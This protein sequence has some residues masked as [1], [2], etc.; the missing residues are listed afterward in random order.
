MD[1]FCPHCTRRV[2]VPDDKAGQVLS[3]PLCAKQFQAPSL[4]PPP[5]TPKAPPPP[6]PTPETKYSA[7]EPPQ[8]PATGVPED[9][10]TVETPQ[11]MG[12]YARSFAIVF[13]S[14]WLAFVPP[15]CLFLIFILS[16]FNWHH[17]DQDHTASLWG[18]SFISQ[19]QAGDVKQAH[20]LAYTI[21]M[22]FPT[23][24]LVAA[25]FA[26]NKAPLPPQVM[27]VKGWLDLAAGLFL[28][29]TF[30]MLC[31]D[32]LDA[33]F[34]ARNNAIALAMKLAIRLHFLAMMASFLMF[35]LHL[36]SR[37]NLPPPRLEVRF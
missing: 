12:D 3:C 31:I 36:R 29:L 1:L 24:L 32:Y 34:V 18:M 8:K 15:V 2:T 16:F 27:V 7:G 37:R 14:A 25:A 23:W 6:A 33:H 20:F 17:V 19:G 21:L 22:L 28:G 10:A 11:P 13:K 30:L 9:P 5:S 26:L 4:A 35:W